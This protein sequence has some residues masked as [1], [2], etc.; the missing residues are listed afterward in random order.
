MAMVFDVYGRFTVRVRPAGE[1]M[2]VEVPRGDGKRH[3][4]PDVVIPVGAADD[5]IVA[6][7]EAVFHETGRPGESIA[8]VE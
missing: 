6:V 5:E 8:R 1:W 3:T 7:L 2:V 4:L